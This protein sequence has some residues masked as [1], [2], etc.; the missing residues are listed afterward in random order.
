MSPSSRHLIDPQL[1][2]LLETLPTVTI[3]AETLAAWR[4]A[5]SPPSPTDVDP[6]MAAVTIRTVSVPGFEG[7][8]SVRLR[9]YQPQ[10]ARPG[11]SCVYH[12]HGGGFISGAAAECESQHRALC[13]ELGCVVISVD[14]RLAPETSFPG[15]IEDCYAGLKWAVSHAAEL[16]I[17]T[18]CIGLMGESAGGGLAAALALLARQRGEFSL[19]FQHLASPMLDD[20]TCLVR[21]S[22]FRGEWVWTRENNRFGWSALLGGAPGGEGVSPYAAPARAESLMG[23]PP[24]FVTIG[25]LDLFL[26]ETIEFARRL[27]DAGVPTELHV[28]PGAFHGFELHPTAAVAH[29]ARHDARAAL[30]R[31]LANV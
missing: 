30:A 20:R 29:A 27:L 14:Y 24:T 15:N 18:R 31:F 19:A 11:A 10:G 28:Y 7:A 25:A 17:D 8:P 23:M 3:T 13:G 22:G 4:A 2:D 21:D 6:A 5:P 26:D 12:I 9:V 1:V 16:N